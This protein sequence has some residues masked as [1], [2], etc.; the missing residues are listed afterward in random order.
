M[1]TIDADRS[2]NHHADHPGFAGLSGHLYAGLFAVIGKA[3]ARL[4]LDLAGVT[5]ADR[6]VDIGCGAG[7][8]VR[9]AAAVGATG[10]G[11]DPSAAMLRV[12]RLL[13]RGRRATFRRGGAET[14]PVAD[15]SAT[16]VWSVAC[17]HHW[18]DVDA[19]LSEVVR[20]LEPGGRFLAVER[21]I[22]AGATGL[23]SHGWTPIQV[24][25]FAGAC[26]AAGL[27]DVTVETVEGRRGT[28]LVVRAHR[29]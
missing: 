1:D 13:T 22:E 15:A 6:V 27:V 25:A 24:D 18:V 19:A 4:V 29:P 28:A 7:N 12:A 23:A 17:V 16:V 14:L 26:R 21:R 5:P 3:N 8:A 20:V 2:P 10:T 11:V 9:A